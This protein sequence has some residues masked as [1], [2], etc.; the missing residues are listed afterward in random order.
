MSAEAGTERTSESFGLD[1]LIRTTLILLY[2]ALAL[3]L[4]LMASGN[5]RLLMLL[6]LPLGL[7]LVLAL[8]SE[9]VTVSAEALERS[10]PAWAAAAFRG[11]SWRVEWP[12][13][14][15]LV[16]VTTSQG[17]RVHYIRTGDGRHLLLPQRL[18][19]FDRFLELLHERSGL[20]LAGVGRLTPPWTYRLLAVLS[21]LM[22]AGEMTAGAL[23]WTSGPI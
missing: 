18:E 22:L 14:E 3:P 21:G 13:V 1:P 8:L 15:R 10:W 4:P 2:G 23:G 5:A 12:L 6:A 9:R 11:S 16:P 19:R 17:G 20:D 7:L